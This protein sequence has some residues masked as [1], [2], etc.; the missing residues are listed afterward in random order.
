[1]FFKINSENFSKRFGWFAHHFLK[2]EAIS[3]EHYDQL[4][5]FL[6]KI[7]IVANSMCDSGRTY[8]TIDHSISDCWM[9]IVTIV[10]PKITFLE[11]ISVNLYKF[12]WLLRFDFI[13]LKKKA[14]KKILT[15]CCVIFYFMSNY[16]LIKK[17]YMAYNRYRCTPQSIKTHSDK[18][19][20]NNFD[21]KN[22]LK[23]NIICK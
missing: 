10:T 12:K 19:P 23:D 16:T 1:M 7:I 15:N 22:K 11:N 21:Y 9:H 17:G 6:E 13:G 18:S 20:I 14:W 3:F 5:R 4:A 2:S 8:E